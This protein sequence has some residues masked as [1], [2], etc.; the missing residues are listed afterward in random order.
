MSTNGTPRKQHLLD[1]AFLLFN[2]FGF[3]ATGIDRIL[4]ESGVSKATLYKHFP[5]KDALVLAVLEKRHTDLEKIF[6]NTLAKK[7]GKEG[8][9]G[10][11]DTLEAWFHSE[12]FHGC[13]FIRASGE[14]AQLAPE[15]YHF[16]AKHKNRVAELIHTHLKKD[17]SAN[18]EVISRKILQLIDGAIIA[19]HM[20][21][22]FQAAKR[23]KEMASIVLESDIPL[24]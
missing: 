20:H 10:L 11:F 9:L 18:A 22:D 4:A 5:S 12:S 2:E 16:A 1:T 17:G 8:I 14:Y 21:H 23:G 6:A 15:I 13:N 19:A 7:E 24:I 3:H